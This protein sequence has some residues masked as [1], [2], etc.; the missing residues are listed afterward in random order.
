MYVFVDESGDAG[1]KFES[2]SSR[3]FVVACLLIDHAEQAD[4]LREEL[5]K[6]KTSLN[7][8]PES[9]F[10]FSKMK[11]DFQRL[12]LSSVDF[13]S[14]NVQVF[15]LDKAQ[16]RQIVAPPWL[17]HV[18][19]L[20]LCLQRLEPEL[21]HAVVKID[22]ATG[23]SHKG[24][25]KDIRPKGSVDRSERAI[26]S[27]RLVRSES[28]ILIQLADMVAGVA[29]RSLEGTG[30]TQSRYAAVLKRVLVARESLIRP[31]IK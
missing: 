14:I 12:V 28:E 30:V 31:L 10:K 13:S 29:R 16:C 3:Y 1:Y 22:G 21:R 15:Y 25:L 18:Q 19:M 2:G 27:L 9:E 23:S 11:F 5:A 8:K 24:V 17:T 4:C 7:W 20:R 6:L 26:R